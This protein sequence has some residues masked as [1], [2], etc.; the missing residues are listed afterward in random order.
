MDLINNIKDYDEINW[1]S[2][3][4]TLRHQNNINTNIKINGDTNGSHFNLNDEVFELITNIEKDFNNDSELKS[5]VEDNKENI[6]N[7]EQFKEEQVDKV[8][9]NKVENEEAI[10]N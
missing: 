5:Q 9:N 8:E 6:V 1:E 4:V 2:I 7:E 3:C 10:K